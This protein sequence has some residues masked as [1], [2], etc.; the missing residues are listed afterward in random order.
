MRHPQTLLF[1]QNTS[2]GWAGA[3]PQGGI[4]V[5]GCWGP[6]GFPAWGLA[7]LAR[8]L[9]KASGTLWALR[10]GL[11]RWGLRAPGGSPRGLE[12]TWEA[13]KSLG[14]QAD[15]AWSPGDS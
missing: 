7:A 12:G 10:F 15:P 11:G 8:P 9:V 4:P 6:A 1:P 5:V 13:P 14:S 3:L 2:T